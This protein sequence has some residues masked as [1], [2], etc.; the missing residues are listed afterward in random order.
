[1]LLK[2]RVLGSVDGRVRVDWGKIFCPL[3]VTPH[4]SVRRVPKTRINLHSP[5]RSD[6]IVHGRADESWVDSTNPEFCLDK[7]C[8]G[9]GE[10]VV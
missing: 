2:N 6:E 3:C 7:A 1:M 10:K 4:L 9:L 8:L 5:H